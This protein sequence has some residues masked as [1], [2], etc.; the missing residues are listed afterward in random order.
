MEQHTP[1]IG[2]T[3]ML[4]IVKVK[5]RTRDIIKKVIEGLNEFEGWKKE[6]SV[7]TAAFNTGLVYD[8]IMSYMRLLGEGARGYALENVFQG[9]ATMTLSI[10]PEVDMKK[11][12]NALTPSILGTRPGASEP[13]TPS[14]DNVTPID[15]V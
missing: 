13:Q 4:E 15:V 8:V 11:I 3:E 6:T 7:L 14:S 9:L 12:V 2:Q 5:R 10:R 1:K